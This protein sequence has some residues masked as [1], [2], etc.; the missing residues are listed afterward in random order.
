MERP[1]VEIAHYADD[2]AAIGPGLE[3]A[4]Q[5]FLRRPEALAFD[6][7]LID[8]QATRHSDTQTSDVVEG[9]TGVLAQIANGG[10]EI[11]SDHVEL[12]GEQVGKTP[13]VNGFP[14]ED[15][16]VGHING[17]V[18]ADA[19]DGLSE[20]GFDGDSASSQVIDVV[21]EVRFEFVLGW[22]LDTSPRGDV[23]M[24]VGTAVLNSDTARR[25]TRGKF[26]IFTSLNMM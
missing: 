14:K 2:F 13:F 10:Q 24:P 7:G 19:S 26:R 5:G 12:V 8:E 17:V 15:L 6:G 1:E 25:A 22:C 21:A 3:P 4:T 20:G 18:V 16:A 11:V 9:I 23:L